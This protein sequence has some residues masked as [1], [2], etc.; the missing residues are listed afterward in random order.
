MTF[1]VEHTDKQSNQVEELC[2]LSMEEPTCFEVDVKDKD[3][4]LAMDEE[5]VMII[6]NQ[7]WYPT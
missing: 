2:C 3:W 6:K 4:R 7:T 5:I 1:T